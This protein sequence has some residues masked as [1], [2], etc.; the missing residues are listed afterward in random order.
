[1]RKALIVNVFV[2]RN[3]NLNLVQVKLFKTCIRFKNVKL[4]PMHGWIMVEFQ[5]STIKLD[6]DSF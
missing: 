3:V 5:D 4:L 6:I 1:M 2:F